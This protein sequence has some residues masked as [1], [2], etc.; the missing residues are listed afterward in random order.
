MIQRS[1]LLAVLMAI[2]FAGTAVAGE[3]KKDDKAEKDTLSKYGDEKLADIGFCF[4]KF[5]ASVS[6]KDVKTTVAF[7]DE[8]PRGLK[9]LDLTKDSDKKAFFKALEKFDGASLV[10]SQKMMGGL[11]EV[12]FTDKDGKDQSQRMQNAGGRWKITGL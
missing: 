10:S 12:K 6:A 4:Q 9:Q 3:A 7:I 8:L 5:C 11:G 2:S 1:A